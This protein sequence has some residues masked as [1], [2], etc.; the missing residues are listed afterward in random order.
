MSVSARARSRSSDSGGGSSG[1]YE[2]VCAAFHS[3]F[4]C[5]RRL[6]QHWR[7]VALRCVAS[8]SNR[9]SVRRRQREA[10]K[11]SGRRALRG[12]VHHGA[13]SV[14]MARGERR[15]QLG[16]RDILRRIGVRAD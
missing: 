12:L 8:L 10:T 14:R 7:A 5:A 11:R 1:L 9:I 16:K 2:R 15:R 4:A 6:V 3:G 13:L